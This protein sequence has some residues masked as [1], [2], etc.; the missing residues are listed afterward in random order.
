LTST[1]KW[2]AVGLMHLKLSF[3]SCECSSFLLSE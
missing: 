2:L 3:G 1:W